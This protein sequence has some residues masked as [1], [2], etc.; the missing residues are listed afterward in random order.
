STVLDEETTCRPE[1]WK[2]GPRP[3][4]AI[5]KLA[6]E[7]L[8]LMHYHEY[9]LPV[10]VSRIDVVFDESEYQDL[11]RETIRKARQGDTVEVTKGEGG[12]HTHVDDVVQAFVL[13]TSTRKSTGH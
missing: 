8:C 2:G 6:T 1:L 5:V 4:Y 11:G 10:T 7:K 13:A 9:E 12:A 3:S